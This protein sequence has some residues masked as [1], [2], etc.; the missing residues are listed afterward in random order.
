MSSWKHCCLWTIHLWIIYIWYMY[1]QDLAL[2]NLQKLI[3]HKTQPTNQPTNQQIASFYSSSLIFIDIYLLIVLLKHLTQFLTKTHTK[4]YT[5]R[6]QWFLK[7]CHRIRTICLFSITG[8]HK[9]LNLL[10]DK[11]ISMFIYNFI[12]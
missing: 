3:C 8:F 1:K 6:N 10:M 2:N 4:M 9:L 12:N 7:E 5:Q 11:S